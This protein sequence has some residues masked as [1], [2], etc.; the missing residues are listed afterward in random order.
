MI[1][2]HMIHM[3]MAGL[4]H[5]FYNWYDVLTSISKSRGG[6]TMPRLNLP[7]NGKSFFCHRRPVV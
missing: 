4:S 5:V 2:D 6:W 7:S 1:I 3:G